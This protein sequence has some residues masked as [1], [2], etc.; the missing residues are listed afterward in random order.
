MD[1]VSGPVVAIALVMAAVFIPTAFIPGITGRMYQQFAVTIAVSVL[2]A[3]CNALSLSPALSALLLRPRREMRGPLGLFFRGFNRVFERVMGGYLDGSRFLIRKAAFAILLLLVAAAVSGLL[4]IRLPGGFVPEEDQG[5]FYVNAQLPLAASLE[6]TA[7]GMDKLDAILKDTPRVK[8]YTGVGGFSLLSAPVTTYNGFYFV[9]LAPW[10]QR[11]EK[12][13]TADVIIRDLNRPLAGGPPAPAFRF[14]PP[15]GPGLGP[16]RGATF[17]LEGGG[18]QGPAFLAQS[19]AKFLQGPRQR[20][21]S[22]P[23]F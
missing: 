18:G 6:R 17:M 8:Y 3:A 12:G 16:A 22:S 4:G 1:E 19:T 13:L 10:D 20:P 11:N 21:R 5:Y 9:S 23:V 7:G 2:I 15:A 14:G